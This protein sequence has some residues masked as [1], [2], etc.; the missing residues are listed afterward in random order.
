MCSKRPLLFYINLSLSLSLLLAGI[1]F[2]HVY[3]FTSARVPVFF[4][5]FKSGRATSCNPEHGLL[6]VWQFFTCIFRRL[7]LVKVSPFCYAEGSRFMPRN[8]QVII[9]PA[10]RHVSLAKREESFGRLR[11]GRWRRRWNWCCCSNGV[12]FCNNKNK[13]S[14]WEK[15]TR[16]FRHTHTHKGSGY[17]W[18]SSSGILRLV[19]VLE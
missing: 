8:A 1:S 12:P 6:R 16:Q 13:N 4:F 3:T 18:S 2:R 9:G 11:Q 10:G 15:L 19:T 7:V 17:L 5:F 14:N